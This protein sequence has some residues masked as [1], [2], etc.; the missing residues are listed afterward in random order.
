MYRFTTERHV[1]IIRFDICGLT[2]TACLGLSSSAFTST[3]AVLDARDASYA[4]D[5]AGLHEVQSLHL[6]HDGTEKLDFA[7][8][9]RWSATPFDLLLVRPSKP[10]S[11]RAAYPQFKAVGD[12]EQ[13]EMRQG[14]CTNKIYL[15]MRS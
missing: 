9:Q 1:S 6:L 5:F 7:A 14:H 4:L 15:Q 10:A 11:N 12:A 3:T 2:R 13:L 8:T